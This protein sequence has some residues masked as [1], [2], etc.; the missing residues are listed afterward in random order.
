MIELLEAGND[1]MLSK[2]LRAKSVE[3]LLEGKTEESD[4]I[5]CLMIQAIKHKSTILIK[6]LLENNYQVNETDFFGMSTYNYL[7]LYG[8]KEI[9][10][11]L[12]SNLVTKDD[13][14][15]MAYKCLNEARV[16]PKYP[17]TIADIEDAHK[18]TFDNGY[19]LFAK[20]NCVCIYCGSK[21]AS[22]E[23][24]DFT[25][26]DKGTALCPFCGIDSVIGEV[27]GY[28]LTDK[29]IEVM[30]EYFFNNPGNTTKHFETRF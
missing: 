19:L 7:E 28:L 27:S 21:F 18:N 1:E 5:F 8:N 25:I 11:L 2:F 4:D 16:K 9:R 26:S 15:D 17:K 30:Y 13:N 10:V 3:E 22:S 14:L 12:S 24:I 29:F 20:Q 6:Y 23:I